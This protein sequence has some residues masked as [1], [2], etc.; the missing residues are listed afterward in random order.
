MVQ[1]VKGGSDAS[2]NGIGGGV[3]GVGAAISIDIDNLE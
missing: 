3:G 2:V 1:T